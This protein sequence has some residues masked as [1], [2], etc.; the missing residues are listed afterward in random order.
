MS[1]G[2]RNA[3]EYVWEKILCKIFMILGIFPGFFIA[4]TVDDLPFMN[5]FDS[6]T[7]LIIFCVVIFL[8]I[9]FYALF[10]VF[11]KKIPFA[12]RLILCLLLIVFSLWCLNWMQ[13]NRSMF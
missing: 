1:E 7:G 13:L 12:V 9:L 10:A 8:V 3:L 2:L 4:K 6:M 11:A 5:S